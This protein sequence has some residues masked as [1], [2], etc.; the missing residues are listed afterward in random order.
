MNTN[1]LDF[2]VLVEEDWLNGLLL[3][4]SGPAYVGGQIIIAGV[5][6]GFDT[7]YNPSPPPEPPKEM[8]GGGNE[9]NLKI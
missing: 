5:G 2:L 4:L 7:P 1:R 8:G 3:A 9:K 6:Q